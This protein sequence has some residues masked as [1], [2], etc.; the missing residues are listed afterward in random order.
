MC[1]LNYAKMRDRIF[2]HKQLELT[3]GKFSSIVLS[4]L[5]F[6]FW[7]H[8]N[9]DS[10][11]STNGETGGLVHVSERQCYKK[12]TIPQC[13]LT[14]VGAVSLQSCCKFLPLWFDHLS[15]DL[16]INAVALQPIIL[17]GCSPGVHTVVQ[18]GCKKAGKVAVLLENVVYYD[19]VPLDSA[20]KINVSAYEAT[21][22]PQQWVDLFNTK[23][24]A[25]AVTDPWLV[26]V[27][28][29]SGVT[30]PVFALAPG[31]ALDE[32]LNEPEPQGSHKPF[33]FG[34]SGAFWDRKNHQLLLRAF[35]EEF[36]NSPDVRLSLHGRDGYPDIV[37]EL[38]QYVLS[39]NLSNVSVL[40]GL[41]TPFAYK[42][43][44]QSL[45]A[46]VLVSKAEGYSISPREAMAL[47]IPCIL[48]NNTA[49]KVLCDTALVRAVAS[50][51]LIDPPL[52]ATNGG[53]M[54]D[55]RVEDVR[56]ALR[57]VYEHFSVYRDKARMSRRWVRQ[58]SFSALKPLYLSLVK[59]KKVILGTENKLEPG[60]LTTTSESLY[61]KYLAI[62]NSDANAV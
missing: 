38:K 12:E 6:S 15:E 8:C 21:R 47:G 52:Y 55:C 13:D 45:D 41:L 31:L 40:E 37:N 18:E 25:V 20:I 34:M 19:Q 57:D 43:F 51:I 23:F 44:M 29:N 54:F 53:K 27:Y 32:F 59:P 35:A 1:W 4:V 50:D 26:D 39:H 2:E 60:C 9:D 28:V 3:M 56:E 48:A 33:T 24:D 42:G 10:R 36:G 17:D 7:L 49:Q 14:L 30:I 5:F 11:V 22:L 46:Y 61:K 16:S 62:I 58:Y